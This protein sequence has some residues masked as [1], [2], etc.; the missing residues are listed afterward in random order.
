M[1][2]MQTENYLSCVLSDKSIGSTAKIGYDNRCRLYL[3]S[4][5][6]VEL[7]VRPIPFDERIQPNFIVINNNKL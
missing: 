5:G 6:Q 2:T 7:Q 3:D 1:F 4:I